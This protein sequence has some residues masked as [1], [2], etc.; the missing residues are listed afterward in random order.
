MPGEL[1]L[2]E[3]DETSGFIHLST[4]LQVPGTLTHFFG[5]DEKMYILKIGFELVKDKIRWE[6][7]D[8]K[9]AAASIIILS[10]L[11]GF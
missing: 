11:T 4:A 5:N 2:S 8:K 7:P 9:G 3:L 10:V 1:P 6:S